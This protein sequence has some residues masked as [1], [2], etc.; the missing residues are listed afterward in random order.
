MSTYFYFISI[1][2]FC[3]L[4]NY[5]KKENDNLVALYSGK[6]RTVSENRAGHRV[7]AE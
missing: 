1:C 2:Y 3:N 6:A 7:G 4:K 5:F